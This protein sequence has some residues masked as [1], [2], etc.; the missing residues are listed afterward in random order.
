MGVYRGS[1]TDL[2]IGRAEAGIGR[3]EAGIGRAEAGTGRNRG[4]KHPPL[5]PPPKLDYR[6]GMQRTDRAGRSAPPP[7]AGPP[8]I[9][10]I[11]PPFNDRFDILKSFLN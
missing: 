1:K 4:S 5:A 6:L 11:K 10:W 2:L 3:A 7:Q 8:P 9:G